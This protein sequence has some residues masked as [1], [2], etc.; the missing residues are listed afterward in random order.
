M[1]VKKYSVIEFPSSGDNTKPVEVVPTTWVNFQDGTVYW[2]PRSLLPKLESIIRKAEER[3]GS[4]W[5][6]CSFERILGQYGK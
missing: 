4:R 3:P 6:I 2:P 5:E 1:S